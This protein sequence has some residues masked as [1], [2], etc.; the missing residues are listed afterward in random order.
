MPLL[1]FW[2]KASASSLI[3]HLGKARVIV[4]PLATWLRLV[5]FPSPTVLPDWRPMQ[6]RMEVLY[7]RAVRGKVAKYPNAFYHSMRGLCSLRRAT[8]SET[9]GSWWPCPRS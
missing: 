3:L 4:V 7:Q 8:R 9:C 1:P 6:A 2:L 5:V